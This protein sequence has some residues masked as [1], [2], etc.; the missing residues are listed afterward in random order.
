MAIAIDVVLSVL[1]SSKESGTP[2]ARELSDEPVFS[3][4]SYDS[5]DINP[6]E[7]DEIEKDLE[8]G[9]FCRN[10]SL[11]LYDIQCDGFELKVADDR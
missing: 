2:S 3:A 1:H 11:V 10:P 8:D 9:I 6:S 4:R 7:I 5:G